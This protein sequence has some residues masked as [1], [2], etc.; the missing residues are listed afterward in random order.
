MSE[1]VKPGICYEVR[2]PADDTTDDFMVLC[3]CDSPQCASAIV[4]SLMSAERKKPRWVTI[5]P[6]AV[7]P[8]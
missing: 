1:P 2:V 3:R 4:M 5:A 8:G 7:L 6:G